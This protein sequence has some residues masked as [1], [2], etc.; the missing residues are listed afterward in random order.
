MPTITKQDLAHRLAARLQLLPN[1]AERVVDLILDELKHAMLEGRRI[2]IRGFGAFSPHERAARKGVNPR[3]LAAVNIPA[4]QVMVFKPSPELTELI[5]CT[6]D[7]PHP[8]ESG[9]KPSL[10]IRDGDPSDTATRP[11]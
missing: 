8:P 7:K 11:L 6:Q 10:A 4:K 3:N 2:E 5:N 9:S 1:D